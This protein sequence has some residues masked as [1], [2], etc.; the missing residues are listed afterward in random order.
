ML[1]EFCRQTEENGSDDNITTDV[2]EIVCD[3]VN[4][5]HLPEDRIQLQSFCQF[6]I[7]PLTF[8]TDGALIKELLSYQPLKK[9]SET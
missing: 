2:R 6:D 1:Y 4:W 7:E 8:T 9:G 5:I 3:G